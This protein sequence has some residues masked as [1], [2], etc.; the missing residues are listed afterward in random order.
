MK[1]FLPHYDA[2]I[3]AFYSVSNQNLMLFEFINDADLIEQWNQFYQEHYE[4]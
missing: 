3:D 4:E 2:L 1:D